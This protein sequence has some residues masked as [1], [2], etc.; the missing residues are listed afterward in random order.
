MDAP[1][2]QLDRALPSEGRGHR[3]ESCRV[4]Q[5]AFLDGLKK[6][7]GCTGIGAEYFWGMRENEAFIRNGAPPPLFDETYL[8]SGD[9]AM[10]TLPPPICDRR[11]VRRRLARAAAAG[12]EEFLHASEE[13][14]KRLCLPLPVA[15]APT[16][17]LQTLLR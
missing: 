1:V 10:T 17:M 14:C 8:A 5:I 3:F 4:R 15:E 13:F 7:T 9:A 2:A 6:S 16:T 12:A 11:L